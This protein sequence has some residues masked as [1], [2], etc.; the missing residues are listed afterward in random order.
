MKL[1]AN[2][3]D[4]A[5]TTEYP[6]CASP[7]FMRTVSRENGWIEGVDDAG[8]RHCVVPYCV[9]RKGGMTLLRFTSETIALGELALEDEKQFL[10]AVVE[11][12]RPRGIDVIVPATFSSLFR[13]APDGAIAAP[14]G[15]FVVD[16]QQDEEKLWNGVH[17]KH[18]NKIRAAMKQ[19]VTVRLANDRLAEAT[20]LVHQSFDRSTKGW[21]PRLRLRLR[22]RSDSIGKEV[23]ALGPQAAV[24]V[25]EFEGRIQGSAIIPFSRHCAYNMHAGSVADP[26]AGTTNLLQWEIMR[27]FRAQGVRYYNFV[28]AR[29]D[30]EPGSK[31]EGLVNFKKRFGGALLR[32][33]MWRYHL[34]PAKAWMY[35]LASRMRSGGDIVDQESHKLRDAVSPSATS[36]QVK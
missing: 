31:Q 18:R 3:V 17:S 13:V 8:K 26:V 27:Y 25:A 32:G 14:Y 10:N 33:F 30:P 34:N 15:S 29:I 16:L 24:F 12:L 36:V 22:L 23:R 20:D 2:F 21:L 6:V 35:Q 19:G 9:I 28:G 1:R 7:E 5:W 11:L 4:A